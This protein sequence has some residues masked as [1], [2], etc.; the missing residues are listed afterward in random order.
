MTFASGCTFGSGVTDD[1]VLYLL[2]ALDAIKYLVVVLLDGSLA[3]DDI[4]TA[5]T[6]LVASAEILVGRYVDKSRG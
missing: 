1:T 2:L 5:S 4:L 3:F 6:I